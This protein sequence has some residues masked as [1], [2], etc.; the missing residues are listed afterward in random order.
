VE[1]L[2]V[3]NFLVIKN[4]YFKVGK[5]NLIIGPQ[6]SGKSVLAKLLYF[7][8]EFLN[9]T[10]LNTVKTQGK[11]ISIIK[12]GK[13][14]FE[15]YFPKYTWNNKQFEIVYHINDIEVKILRTKT[16]SG[17]LTL[18]LNYSKNLETLNKKLKI[19]YK[20]ELE[21]YQE[22]GKI[23]RKRIGISLLHFL[24]KHLYKTEIGNSFQRSLFIPASRSFFAN[25][26][27]N[28][29]TFLA[30]NID[31]DPFIKDF[32]SE[33]ESIKR[34]YRIEFEGKN[35]KIYDLKK[36]IDRLVEVVLV[37]KYKYEDEKD[38]IEHDNK[39]INLSNAS[40]GQQEALPMLLNMSV[41]PFV[42]E[43]RKFTFFI[44]EP[45]AHL[46]P[47][48]QKHI[49]S[50]FALIYN[51][52]K[53][54]FVFTTHSPYILTAINNMILAYDI[55]EEKGEKKVAKIMD[56]DFCIK[57]KDVRAYTIE[58]GELK[59]ILNDK[60]RLIGS[61]II[62]SVSDEFENVFNKLLEL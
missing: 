33:Y 61:S 59:S 38:W 36:K 55:K 16:I 18:R 54:G 43:D 45:E 60:T 22:E 37:G 39:K 47:V 40:S 62:D 49:M 32:G 53:H 19:A 44:E 10:Y 52:M 26:Q 6:A 14:D 4:A 9:E 50:L 57:Y 46:F 23:E 24:D 7:F 21:E 56:V 29:F 51:H 2:T 48:S 28:V 30:N 13:A 8:R 34:F 1:S 25:L 35:K 5:I 41:W 15:Q 11:K 27:K 42:L 31:I 3:K 17:N 58:N 20:K 12:N